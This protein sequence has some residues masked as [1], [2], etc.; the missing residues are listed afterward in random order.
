MTPSFNLR[1]LGQSFQQRAAWSSIALRI[2]QGS[3][4]F[5]ASFDNQWHPALASPL[6]DQALQNLQT[7]EWAQTQL[8]RL[9]SQARES[10]MMCGGGGRPVD[11]RWLEGGP[12][13]LKTLFTRFSPATR[14][15]GPLCVVDGLSI[16]LSLTSKQHQVGR[17]ADPRPPGPAEEWARRAEEPG[18]RKAI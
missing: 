9:S 16:E 5:Q 4:E 6:Q 17:A 1:G 12:D 3:R 8:G 15:R 7:G 2:P 11:G 14:L 18:L 10:T 13:F